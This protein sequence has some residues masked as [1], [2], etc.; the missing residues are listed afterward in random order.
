MFLYCLQMQAEV[1]PRSQR[2]SVALDT[3]AVPSTESALNTPPAAM[4][5]ILSCPEPCD[6]VGHGFKVLNCYA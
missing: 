2:D 5:G 3:V 6:K 4:G 1:P